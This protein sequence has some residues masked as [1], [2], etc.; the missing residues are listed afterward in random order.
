M[1]HVES[2]REVA[3]NSFL[4]SEQCVDS[5]VDVISA[6]E[7]LRSE[8]WQ[9]LLFRGP[10]EQELL[11]VIS[12]VAELQLQAWT[13]ILERFPSDE[14]L[15][16]IIV[17]IEPMRTSTWQLLLANS[18]SLETVVRIAD[19][20]SALRD[21]AWQLIQNKVTS[22]EEFRA[23]STP[24][25][26]WLL[27]KLVK[28]TGIDD[29][30]D[31]Y[32]LW[33]ISCSEQPNRSL[34]I[35]ELLRKPNSREMLWRVLIDNSGSSEW[36]DNAGFCIDQFLAMSPSNDELVE[37]AYNYG[38]VSMRFVSLFL[39]NGPNDSEIAA[40][41]KRFHFPGARQGECHALLLYLYE[42][43]K[44]RG[45]WQ[46]MFELIIDDSSP[47]CTLGKQFYVE[48]GRGG[49]SARRYAARLSKS[50]TSV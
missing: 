11:N 4:K 26:D 19:K 5:L 29:V 45:N 46:P 15:K 21:S 12:R 18:P 33:L 28:T 1:K 39:E 50:F 3:W 10:S 34:A 23:S 6:V 14:Y 2:L 22:W 38:E 43:C 20:V 36:R 44:Q 9:V 13:L 8:A 31:D 40:A 37:L 17:A 16:H 42:K 24:T 25:Y 32:L 47:I 7:P 27:E 35:D 30:P 49:S 48:L 41:L